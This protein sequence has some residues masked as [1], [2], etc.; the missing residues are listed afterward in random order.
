MA[1]I[2]RTFHCRA[3]VDRVGPGKQE[4]MPVEFHQIKGR[5]RGNYSQA[6]VE[7]RENAKGPAQVEML[8]RDP[9]LAVELIQQQGR[10]QETLNDEETPYPQVA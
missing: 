3:I 2:P 1:D 7:R 8:E 6:Q 5:E 10:Y 9:T 4:V